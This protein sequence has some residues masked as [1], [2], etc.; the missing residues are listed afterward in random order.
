M[1][2]APASNAPMKRGQENTGWESRRSPTATAAIFHETDDRESKRPRFVL[3][4][5]KDQ[6]GQTGR[7]P[8][9]GVA[10]AG[11]TG[12]KPLPCEE[13]EDQHGQEYNPGDFRVDVP[14]R[15]MGERD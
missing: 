9:I 11:H 15:Q 8:A 14:A 4:H 12:S 10:G 7:K 1:A 2:T 13:Q 3:N 6:Q 5:R